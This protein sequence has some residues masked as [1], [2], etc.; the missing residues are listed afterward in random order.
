MALS[1]FHLPRFHELP[2]VP[3][4]KEQ[5]IAYLEDVLQ[6][7]TVHT[8]EKL[9][10][11]TMLNNYVKQKIVSPPRDKKYTQKHMAYLM[12]VCLLKQVFTLHEICYLIGIQIEHSPIEP[13]YDYF[14]TEVEK[15]LEAAF[16]TRDF[17]YPS[18]AMVTTA[19]SELLRSVVMSFAHKLFT[20]VQLMTGDDSLTTHK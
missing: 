19:E 3:L 13:A 1:T 11:P 16:D 17:S 6:P 9:L 4:Y 12:V 20:Q 10:T 5:V 14:C 8:N 18:S 7:L 15:A 2:A